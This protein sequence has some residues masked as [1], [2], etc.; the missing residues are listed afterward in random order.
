[1]EVSKVSILRLMRTI[2]SLSM[3]MQG[4]STGSLQARSVQ[5]MA[6]M[7]WLATCPR[8]SPVISAPQSSRRAIRS[9]T[10]IM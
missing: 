6:C 5:P 4:R 10:R 7:V 3:P 2:S 8:L 1:M 9:A